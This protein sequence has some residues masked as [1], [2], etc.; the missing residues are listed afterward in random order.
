MEQVA[1]AAKREVAV[2]ADRVAGG[3]HDH[4]DWIEDR[5]LPFGAAIFVEMISSWKVKVPPTPLELPDA[6]VPPGRE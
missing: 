6:P 1:E 3:S 4:S 2:V 5:R